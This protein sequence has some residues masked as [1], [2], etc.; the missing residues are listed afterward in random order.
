MQQQR[1]I[2]MKDCF[3]CRH[4]HCAGYKCYFCGKDDTRDVYSG[5]FCEDFEE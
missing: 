5:K 2:Q 3:D 1:R 4:C